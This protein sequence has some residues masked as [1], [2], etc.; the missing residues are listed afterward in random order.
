VEIAPG[1][2]RIACPFG[3]R[4]VYC[5]L[6]VGGERVV[7]IDTGMADSPEKHIF[8]YM[9]Q[10]GLAPDRIDLVAITHSDVDHQG[11]NDV[12]KQAAPRALFACHA[13]DAPWI[14]SPEALIAGRYSQFEAKH[15]IG[16]GPQGKA[17]T[18]SA[19]LSHVRMDWHLQGGEEFRIDRDRYLTFIHTP[20]HSWGHTVV[21]DE[22]TGTMIAGEAALWKTILGLHNQPALPPTYCYIDTYE[23]TLERLMAMPIRTYSGAHWPV[24]KGNDAK[25]FLAESL[26]YCRETEQTLL[27]LL[28]DAAEPMTLKEIITRLNATLGTWP[29]SSSQDLAYP[30]AGHLQR[31]VNRGLIIEKSRN[32]H[33]AYIAAEGAGSGQQAAGGR[34]QGPK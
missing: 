28:Q 9:R 5:H 27:H 33:A 15:G 7:L 2:Y 4:V 19:C 3:D 14:E 6:I 21:W 8:P 25:A 29:E 13:L 30:L 1:I 17:E 11:G 18:A 32:G 31:L 26:A 23:A 24:Q 12:I 10:I 34:Q 20:G 22:Q 16:P